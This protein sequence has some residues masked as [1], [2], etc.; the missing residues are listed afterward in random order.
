M[1]GKKENRVLIVIIVILSLLL[2]GSGGYIYYLSVQKVKETNNNSIDKA[3]K[4]DS[5]KVIE[6]D[7][8]I[9]VTS[10][11]AM[12]ILQIF[13]SANN[14]S[15]DTDIYFTDKKF[16]LSDVDQSLA[17]IIALNQMYIPNNNKNNNIDKGYAFTSDELHENIE[18]SF[19]K[20]Y[21]Y[22]DLSLI[23]I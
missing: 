14:S 10:D 22:E 23:H 2:V 3:S 5:S 8:V 16:T 4:N 15:N 7:E 21:K 20:D 11:E 9:D 17:G 18:K 1:S 12:G 19:G 13:N 6:C